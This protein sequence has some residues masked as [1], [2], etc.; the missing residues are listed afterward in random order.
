MI[1]PG[2]MKSVLHA[3]RMREWKMRKQYLMESFKETNQSEGS[4]ICRRIILKQLLKK[5]DGRV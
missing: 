5:Q 3:A 4:A 2:K 1:K